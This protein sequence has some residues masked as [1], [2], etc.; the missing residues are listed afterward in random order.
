MC[1][2]KPGTRCEGSSR[3]TLDAARAHAT[4][5]MM[6]NPYDTEALEKALDRVQR[7]QW[8][9]DN[10]PTGK[11]ELAARI[12]NPNTTD[13]ARAHLH[14]YQRQAAL[15]AD[16]RAQQ[17]ALMPPVEKATSP[18]AQQARLAIGR[19]REKLAY[20][21]TASLSLAGDEQDTLRGKLIDSEV[22][23][24]RDAIRGLSAEW[25]LPMN[26][27]GGF[28]YPTQCDV[29]GE[30]TSQRSAAGN[31]TGCTTRSRERTDRLFARAGARTSRYAAAYTLRDTWEQVANSSDPS[32]HHRAM[33]AA[34]YMASHGQLQ[35]PDCGQWMA[36]RFPDDHQCPGRDNPMTI[37]G[38]YMYTGHP[39]EPT[40]AQPT[41]GLPEDAQPVLGDNGQIAGYVAPRDV[42][43]GDGTL[44]T[45][46]LYRPNGRPMPVSVSGPAEAREAL[47]SFND[48]AEADAY[49]DDD[50][51]DITM[52]NEQADGP[53]PAY[54]DADYER[55]Y[56]AIANNEYDS[57]DG[58]NDTEWREL[59]RA[60]TGR[61]YGNPYGN[62][63]EVTSQYERVLDGMGDGWTLSNETGHDYKTTVTFHSTPDEKGRMRSI[64]VDSEELDPGHRLTGRERVQ[65]IVNKIH[66]LQARLDAD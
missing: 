37:M 19:E 2:P 16:M 52:L 29:C 51:A 43:L 53:S 65:F 54:T 45:W 44:H 58:T 42:D 38:G 9:Y 8:D 10:T 25:R 12:A 27:Q 28:G 26:D 33:A 15:L 24:A 32:D 4:E 59:F 60:A 47:Q 57:F 36:A 20:A 21:I 63:S 18:G 50:G 17:V 7:A 3:R 14:A 41:D 23:D 55:L 62:A 5:T 30:F 34:D 39:T 46:Q 1:N 35:C 49:G 61:R 64:A 6:T 13:D 22:D 48:A 40:P 11:A 66:E 56:E 31:H